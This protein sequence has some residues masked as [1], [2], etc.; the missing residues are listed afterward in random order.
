[1]L[2]AVTA[3]LLLLLGPALAGAGSITINMTTSVRLEEGVLSVDLKVTNSGDEAAGSVVPVLRLRDREARGARR[4]SLGPNQA[5]QETLSVPAK[6]LGPGRWPFRVAVD[7]TDA[8]QYPFQAL[9]VALVTVG[10]P[11]PARIAVPEI[12]VPAIAS[13]GTVRMQVKNLAGVARNVTLN[14]FVPE[15][16]ELTD[17]IPPLEIAAWETKEVRASLI[18]RTALAGSRYPVFVSVEYEDGEVYQTVLAYNTVEI[19]APRALL[20]RGFLPVVVALV[21]LWV[22]VIAW[23]M[24]RRRAPRSA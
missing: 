13:S 4:E 14:L 8:N 10:S 22:A 12:K 21:V 7:Y 19:R 3:V 1:M 18:N 20:S 17:P 9:H 11:S 6:D 2:P 15:E 16:L 23:R 24:V 5:L